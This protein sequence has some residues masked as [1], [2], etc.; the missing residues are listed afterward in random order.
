MIRLTEV[1]AD[2][3]KAAGR[4]SLTHILSSRVAVLY[5][6]SS[7][8]RAVARIWG[9]HKVFQTAYGMP[10]LYVIELLGPFARLT[11]REKIDAIAHELAHISTTTSGALRPHN[12]ALW[13]DYRRYKSLFKCDDF[14]S[15]KV[16]P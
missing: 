15:L 11:C 8:S 2:I 16:R 5:N 4:Y 1:K 3:F 12:R 13:R 9:L 14:P 6:S 10:P 7:K